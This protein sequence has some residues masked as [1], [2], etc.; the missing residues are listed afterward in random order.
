VSFANEL[1]KL[2]RARGLSQ[3]DLAERAGISIDSLRNWEQGRVL[4]RIDAAHRLARALG[5]SIDALVEG[6]GDAAPSRAAKRKR[7]R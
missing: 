2:R 1:Q 5:V 6:N 4:P 7:G 3:T